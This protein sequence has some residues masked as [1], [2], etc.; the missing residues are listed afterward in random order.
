VLRVEN[1]SKRFGVVQALD[2]VSLGVERGEIHALVGENG[3]GKSTLTRIVGGAERADSGT[4]EF[5]SSPQRLSSPAAALAAGVS[6]VY[7]HLNLSQELTVAGNMYLGREPRRVLRGVDDRAMNAR[8]R[9]WLERLGVGFPPDALVA[10]LSPS[11]RQLAEIARGLSHEPKLLIMDE[12]TASLEPAS[13]AR[14][15]AVLRELTAAGLSVIYITHELAHV[16]ELADSVTVLKDGRSTLSVPIAETDR[17]GVIRAMVGRTVSDLFPARERPH[18]PAPP[19]LEL[20]ELTLPGY[21]ED[22]SLTV[23]PGQVVGLG[24]LIGSG[25]SRVARAIFGDKPERSNGPLRGEV[26]IDGEAFKPRGPRSAVS[27]G[28]GYVPEDRKAAGLVLG[29]SVAENISLSQLELLARG[30]VLPRGAEERVAREQVEALRIKT[31]SVETEVKNLSGGNQQKV[32]LAKWLA[33]GCKVLIL[34][35]PTPGVDIGAK[36][37]IYA[38]VRTLADSGTAVLL[39]SS[40]LPELLGLSDTILVMSRGRVVSRLDGEAATEEGVMRAAFDGIEAAV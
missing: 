2:G 15:F 36:A 16:F 34:D 23:E 38:L 32:V 40:D 39:I 17:D 22:V 10:D 9:D 7:Q 31:P 21:F 27:R 25:R 28:V 11:D 30:G 24:G 4:I 20:R 29:A 13:A 6:I 8:A 37:E 14:V 12:P 18:E 19:A 26:L 35:E 5:E 1:V 33:R 3:A